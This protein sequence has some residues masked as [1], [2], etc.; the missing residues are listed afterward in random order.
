MV[1]V[2]E[3]NTRMTLARVIKITIYFLLGKLIHCL[4]DNRK[5]QIIII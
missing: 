5:R 1:E 4:N 3:E 2:P